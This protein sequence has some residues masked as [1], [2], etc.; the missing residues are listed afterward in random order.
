MCA[1]IGSMSVDR[2]GQAGEA[3][4]V[5][6]CLQIRMLFTAILT[7]QKTRR[8][9]GGEGGARA[10]T[11]IRVTSDLLPPPSHLCWQNN[12]DGLQELAC[13]GLI[14]CLG[15]VF[16]KSDGI[17]P[18]AHAIWHLFVATAAAVHYYA[19]WKYLYRSPTDFIRHLWP[20]CARFSNQ[21]YHDGGTWVGGGAGGELN[22]AHRRRVSKLALTSF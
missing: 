4:T 11:H 18:F 1:M 9:L 20:V 16:F 2:E 5:A 3:F 12:T 14:Y 8:F 7:V 17:I 19:I 22:V 10:V 15:V 13:G 6:F 21:Y